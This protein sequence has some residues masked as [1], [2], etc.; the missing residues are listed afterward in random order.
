MNWKEFLLGTPP[1]APA[2]EPALNEKK[3][4]TITRDSGGAYLPPV[5]AMSAPRL[6][7]EVQNAVTYG[8]EQSSW[9]QS[10]VTKKSKALSS[11][12][13]ILERR[14]RKGW[15]REEGHEIAGLLAKPNPSMSMQDVLERISMHMD[16]NGNALVHHVRDS[17]GR[18]LEIWPLVPGAIR[19]ERYAG[20]TRI[21]HYLVN[22]TGGVVRISADEV[23]HFMHQHPTD[24]FWGLSPL[25]SVALAIDTDLEAQRWNRS[26]LATGAR[27]GGAIILDDELDPDQQQLA[28]QM[29][30]EQ[31]G[32]A[33]ASRRF[34]VMGGA[35][36]IESFGWNSAEMDYLNGR[37]FAR[38]EI[39]AALNVPSILVAQGQDAT[40]ANMSE[41]KKHFW[42]D[43]L[44]PLLHDIC[45]SLGDS[46]I[47]N[48]G[49]DPRNYRVVPDLSRVTALSENGE[50]QARTNQQKAAAVAL[51]VRSGAFTPES[52]AESIGLPLV[53][54]Q[55]QASLSALKS[56]SLPARQVIERKYGVQI[57]ELEPNEALE[58]ARK[59]SNEIQK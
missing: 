10:A 5:S 21:E 13:L 23:T 9:L 40:Y 47:R 52:I 43:T 59:E 39:C 3:G 8:L 57:D 18:T 54:V 58:I 31:I 33:S 44:I 29:I 4:V 55:A 37:K 15:V 6:N 51:L 50:T 19:P 30:N 53:T 35:K 56:L 42:E 49:L 26:T 36:S 1:A 16:I 2:P 22:T 48:H 27:P 11:V 7:G 24:Q 25:K 32:G 41:A 12:E 38:D 45:K 46:L 14:G 20:M 28:T 34:I 17:L